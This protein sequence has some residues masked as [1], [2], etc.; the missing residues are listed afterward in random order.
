MGDK[1]KTKEELLDEV[2]RLRSRI[3]AFES[4]ESGNPALSEKDKARNYLDVAGVMFIVVDADERVSLIN[5]KGCEILRYGESEIIGK[6]W[7][8][9]IPERMREDVRGI[10]KKLMTGEVEPVEYFENP[11]LTKDGDEKII[12]WH[13][14]LLRDDDG[15]ITATLSSGEDITKRREMEETLSAARRK[16]E[17]EA[18][19]AEKL[20]SLGVLAGGIAHEFNNLLTAILGNVSLSKMYSKPGYEAFDMLLEIEKASIRA[21]GLTQQLLAFSKGDAPVKKTVSI[22]VLLRDS[23]NLSLNV[24]NIRCELSI[25][26]DLP[27]VVADG[28][29]ITQA[30]GS[31]LTNAQQ[32]MP[33]GGVISVTGENVT[34][35]KESALPLEQ[36]RYV[37]ITVKDAGTGIPAEHIQKIFDPF[38]TTKEGAGGL[39]LTSAYSIVKKHG[40]YIAVESEPVA[41][42]TFRIYLPASG[43]RLP[44]EEDSGSFSA[45]GKG[46]V[47]V[48]DDE[49]LVRIVADRMLVQCGYEAEAAEDGG[50]AI[51]LY[52]KAK[53]AGKPFD[54]VIIDI[55]V[56]S[57][58]GG[59]E[60]MEKLLELDPD[61]N[62]I[63][64]SGYSDAPLMAEYGKYGF[65]GTLP[66]PYETAELS[67]VLR[68]VIKGKRSGGQ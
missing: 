27:P 13:N 59:K 62:A 48:M 7:F 33:G 16:M 56:R 31:L 51:E 66:K 29:Q 43:E 37:M 2:A 25:P 22:S 12:A 65:K 44:A 54:V 3:A 23:I 32:S 36:G 26:D 55:V 8:E 39:G 61:A 47:L 6:N 4:T 5:K 50:S 24:P 10:F 38:F 17:A 60:M 53:E 57:G 41:G 64:S 18:L 1:S 42:S 30:V 35:G 67:R 68:E 46:R 14:T 63:V 20:E 45:A 19:R 34:M 28:G 58:M 49:E 15:R 40:G 21:K 52:R 9:F 11:V